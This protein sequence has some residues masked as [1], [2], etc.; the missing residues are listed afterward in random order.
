M[1]VL[2]TSIDSHEKIQPWIVKIRSVPMFT[3]QKANTKINFSEKNLKNNCRP[4]SLC[5][6]FLNIVA[7]AWVRSQLQS[8]RKA[9]LV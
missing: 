5:C 1:N 8:N 9:V 6:N 2:K 4:W 3:H 7:E